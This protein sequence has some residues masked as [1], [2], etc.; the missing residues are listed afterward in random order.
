MKKKLARCAELE[1]S[2]PA[3]AEMLRFYRL[4][5]E[6]QQ[7]GGRV[8]GLLR[9]SAGSGPAALAAAARELLGKPEEWESLRRRE[10]SEA[11]RAFFAAVMLQPEEVV[12]ARQA[13]KPAGGANL[14]PY[15]GEP[16]LV[17]ILRPEGDGGKR[18]LMC[19]R[20]LTEWE[21]R[22]L[23]CPN[24]REEDKEKLPVYTAEEFPHIR[25]EGCDTCGRYLKAIDLTKNGLAIPEVDEMASLSLDVWA[26]EQ[27][28]TKLRANLFG[29]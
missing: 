20:C 7:S 21:F 28:Y 3:A 10:Q 9:L 1:R 25:V 12:A 22:R 6:F 11:A 23:L 24:C 29:M 16:P 4:V 19:G 5:L 8:E 15:C 14:C 17:A 13:S 18:S 27:G 26:A 2:V